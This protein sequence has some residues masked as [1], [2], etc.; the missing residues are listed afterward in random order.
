[1]ASAAGLLAGELPGQRLS[2]KEEILRPKTRQ[3]R[4][5]FWVRSGT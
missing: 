5:E 3:T 2:P 1:M 4:S